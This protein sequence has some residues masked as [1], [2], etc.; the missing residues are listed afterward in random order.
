MHAYVLGEHGDSQFPC[1]SSAHI[2][3]VPLLDYPGLGGRAV[4]DPMAEQTKKKAY[5]IIAAKGTR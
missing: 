5:D 3:G 2:G 4:L 1:W